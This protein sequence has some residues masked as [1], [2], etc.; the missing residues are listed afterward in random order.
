MV[1]PSQ[2]IA[3]G[4]DSATILSRPSVY[5]VCP[6]LLI[7]RAEPRTAT[8]P[9]AIAHQQ[10]H[11]ATRDACQPE[12][13]THAL[14]SEC[15]FSSALYSPTHPRRHQIVQKNVRGNSARKEVLNLKQANP[16]IP[17]R[18]P[19]LA[20]GFY[21]SPTP[22]HPQVNLR[23]ALPSNPSPNPTPDQV[24]ELKKEN[25]WCKCFACFK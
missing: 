12:P 4:A 2:K 20:H 19:S 17:L 6:S 23:S 1:R 18:D 21:S 8:A 15:P 10:P 9:A 22:S 7:R 25:Q 16:P 3:L 14:R 11:Y 5:A 24:S 13:G